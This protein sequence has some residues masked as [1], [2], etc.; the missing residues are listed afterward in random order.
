MCLASEKKDLAAGFI[1]KSLDASV[2]NGSVRK[3]RQQHPR[4]V[5]Y[6]PMNLMSRKILMNE[7]LVR[8]LMRVN[9]PSDNKFI[10]T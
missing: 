6:L 9:L 2:G 8:A 5:N 7:A 1:K 4:P 3:L 10:C